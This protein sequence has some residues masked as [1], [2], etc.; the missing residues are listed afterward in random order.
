MTYREFCRALDLPR[1]ELVER[2]YESDW[3][4]AAPVDTE[5]IR[6][7]LPENA[8][9]V[10]QLVEALRAD[11]VKLRYVN[12]LKA[13]YWTLPQDRVPL[14]PQGPGRTL[15]NLG[16]MVALLG[17]TRGMEEAMERRG[18]P[19]DQRQWLRGGFDRTLTAR[20]AIA[21]Y[22]VLPPTFFFWLR[23]HLVPNLFKLGQLSFELL[24]LKPP[25]SVYREEATGRL[26]G[27]REDGQ[28]ETAFLCTE[29]SRGGKDG[30]A[31]VLDKSLF[32]PYLSPGDPVISVHIPRGAR[33]DRAST[34]EDF[35]AA[36]AFFAQ[37]YP[38]EPL[39][40]FHCSS[41]LL[42][43][44]M[45]DYLSENS[46][47]LAFQKLFQTFCVKSTG[48]EVFSFVHPQPFES[49][50]DLPETTSLERMLKRRYLNSDPV[51]VH[52]GICPF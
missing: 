33:I 34:R 41:W 28:T 40:C 24:T 8:P 52:A 49:Y 4:P 25:M 45:A 31:Y 50:E 32:T 2:I 38:E 39:K 1:D 9:V 44:T 51:F 47:I 16:P 36:R 20:S 14:L 19:E 13:C 12:L 5:P 22:P 23:R 30:P 18:I 42:D 35:A 48:Q 26:L 6:R 17:F 3:D 37:Y 7:L 21:G 29:L 10:L 43:K 15:A 27:L 11:P 46:N